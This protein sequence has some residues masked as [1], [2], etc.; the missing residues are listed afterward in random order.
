MKIGQKRQKGKVLPQVEPKILPQEAPEEK[1]IRVDGDS[2]FAPRP[3]E[4][5]SWPMPQEVGRNA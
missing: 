2:I 5:P 1:P 4:V 3:I